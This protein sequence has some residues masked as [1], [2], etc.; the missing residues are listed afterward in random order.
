MQSGESRV[1]NNV[2][3]VWVGGRVRKGKGGMLTITDTHPD[4]QTH[5]GSI[6][7]V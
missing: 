6:A 7:L 2:E 5:K 3:D 4:I 1:E